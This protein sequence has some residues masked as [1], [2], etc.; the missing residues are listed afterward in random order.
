MSVYHMVIGVGVIFY[1]IGL[2]DSI[3]RRRTVASI[4]FFIWSVLFVVAY[5]AWVL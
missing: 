1:T 5:L 3:I 2:V 4:M